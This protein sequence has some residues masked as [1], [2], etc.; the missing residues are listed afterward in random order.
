MTLICITSKLVFILLICMCVQCRAFCPTVGLQIVGSTH[1]NSG[2]GVSLSS[3][4]SKLSISLE[5]RNKYSSAFG[6]GNG[7]SRKV[8]P[9]TVTNV[10]VFANVL[11]YLAGN[12]LFSSQ[13]KNFSSFEK[14]FTHLL[15]L[16]FAGLRFPLLKNDIMKIDYRIARGEQYR[17]FTALFAH[18]NL[19]HLLM[20]CLSLRSIGPEVKLLHSYIITTMFLSKPLVSLSILFNE[21]NYYFEVGICYFAHSSCFSDGEN[22]RQKQI[23]PHI[24]WKWS[25]CKCCH[26]F[27]RNIS[28]F[29]GS[30]WK[31]IW[32]IRG[33]CWILL[34]K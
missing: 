13:L 16:L 23:S 12:L 31:C 4:I 10:L 22:I 17:L 25:D 28:V 24:R 2:V 32:R 19:Q 29:I 8:V 18:G 27:G 1:S 11:I 14:L 3:P 7:G 33:A 20:N 9:L 15:H 21:K 34:F 26:L 30:I 5:A 6:R